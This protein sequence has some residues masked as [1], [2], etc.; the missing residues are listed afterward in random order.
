[1]ADDTYDISDVAAHCDSFISRLNLTVDNLPHW[2]TLAADKLPHGNAI[3]RCRTY[4]TEDDNYV[5]LEK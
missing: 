3:K 4:V 1:M 2:Y 5:E